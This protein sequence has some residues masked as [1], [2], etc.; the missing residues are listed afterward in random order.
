[1]NGFFVATEFAIVKVRAT[2]LRELAESGSSTARVA[3][4]VVS[5]LNAYLSACQLGITGASL[6][7]GWI[8]E[9]AFAHLFEPL[10]GVLGPWA[11]TGAHAAAIAL[12]F[13]LITVLHIVLGEQAPKAL[14]I[15]HPE[16]TALVVARP[17]E[18]FFRLF[19]PAIWA[20]NAMANGTLRLLGISPGHG[21]GSGHSEEELRILLIES[22]GP[23]AQG[24]RRRALLEQALEFPTRRVRQLM[25]P[26]ADISYLDVLSPLPEI[27]DTARREGYTRYPL[28]KDHLDE[29][30]GIVHV[31]DLFANAEALR[32]S[33]DVARLAREPLFVP[34]SATADRLLRLFQQRRLHMAIVV[35]EYG[36]TSGLASLEDVIEE[37]AGEIQDEFDVEAP[38]V[39]EAGDGLVRV[40][41]SYPVA[42]LARRLGVDIDT[43]DAVTVGG[44]I[45]EGLGR[46]ARTG[47][48]VR[49]GNLGLSVIE[50]R[51]RRI[52]RVLAGPYEAVAKQAKPV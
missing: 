50:T 3:Q 42:D 12:A 35:D 49:V 25:V 51:A 24:E 37:L 16:T 44:L 14:A 41:G 36:G 27:L 19:Y 18:L 21:E 15:Q 7:L 9:P 30:I 1:L 39:E 40:S 5:Q 17:I 26:R 28:C 29:V 13:L 11:A 2:R 22:A 38:P 43:E 47:D 33:E 32:S 4:K 20:L 10:F 45:Q 31:R 46:M 52:T 23:G 34:E 8:G 48:M 6:G